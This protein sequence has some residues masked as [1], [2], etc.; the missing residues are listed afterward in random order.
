MK[1][2]SGWAMVTVVAVAVIAVIPA[3]AQ[4]RAQNAQNGPRGG[5]R[6]AADGPMIT[7]DVYF[8]LKDRSEES[9]EAFAKETV[10]LMEKSRGLATWQVTVRDPEA[11]AN[12]SDKDYDV[13]ARMLFRNVAALK[14][15]I[16]ADYHQNWVGEQK[17]KWE[18]V[19]V[20]D[21]KVF[22]RPNLRVGRGTATTN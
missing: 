16:P 3:I 14:E 21:S 12:N 4:Q 8:Q 7:H 20:F 6:T 5:T 10:A 9:V 1:R 17:D 22:A 11:G 2:F 18:S 15:Y 19:R 13:Q